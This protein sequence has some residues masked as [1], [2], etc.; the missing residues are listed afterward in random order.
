MPLSAP[1]PSRRRNAI[2]QFNVNA[3]D[4]NT[5]A[6]VDNRSAGGT[7]ELTTATTVAGRALDLTF[8]AEVG[9]FASRPIS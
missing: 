6:F 4:A 1:T 9:P 5:D 7:V 2:E 8:G 3:G